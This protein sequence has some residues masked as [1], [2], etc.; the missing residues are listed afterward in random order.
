MCE[1]GP[2]LSGPCLDSVPRLSWIL[3]SGAIPSLL[4]VATSTYC[5]I[6]QQLQ[7]RYSP[8]KNGNFHRFLFWLWVRERRKQ[9][10]RD[11]C[12]CLGLRV[13]WKECGLWEPGGNVLCCLTLAQFCLLLGLVRTSFSS[14][15]A[16]ISL[17]FLPGTVLDFKVRII[18]WG[19]FFLGK[20]C[21]HQ[22]LDRSGEGSF[23]DTEG[24]RPQ[25]QAGSMH[26]LPPYSLGKASCTSL[27]PKI[28]PLP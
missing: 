11:C 10:F 18:N 26:V 15:P 4:E 20:Y 5:A 25:S 16:C 13:W 7:W 6:L 12:P 3:F 19:C 27:T 8:R 28:V 24:S 22:I 23:L 14:L 2:V 17:A 1:R 9:V 21:R